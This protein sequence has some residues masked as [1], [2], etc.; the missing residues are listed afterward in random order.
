MVVGPPHAPLQVLEA[1]A[2][3]REAMREVEPPKPDVEDP[4]VV[5][6]EEPPM[7]FKKPAQLLQVAGA[8]AAAGM[9]GL[10]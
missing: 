7:F 10:G 1:V 5:P 4:A 8:A 9:C 2:L 3:L 6:V